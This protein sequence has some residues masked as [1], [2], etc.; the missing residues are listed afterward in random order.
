MFHLSFGCLFPIKRCILFAVI[1]IYHKVSFI[2]LWQQFMDD[3]SCQRRLT[4]FMQ[5]TGQVVIWWTRTE[6]YLE[7]ICGGDVRCNIHSHDPS[8]LQMK[9]M[10]P[11]HR[12]LTNSI[13]NKNINKRKTDGSSYRGVRVVL[14]HQKPVVSVVCGQKTISCAA[15]SDLIK[16]MWGQSVEL[17]IS[18]RSVHFITWS[19]QTFFSETYPE[20]KK[21]S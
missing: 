4:T 19:H 3:Y 12:Q 6:Y 17:L 2:S 13:T 9:N 16:T 5:I 7:T 15:V 11:A 18:L 14:S 8:W 1:Y 20:K 10:K 21:E